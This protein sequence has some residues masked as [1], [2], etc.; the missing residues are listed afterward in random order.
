MRGCAFGWERKNVYRTE[1][2]RW[3]NGRFGGTGSCKKGEFVRKKVC[4]EKAR[5][6]ERDLE[7]E[8]LWNFVSLGEKCVLLEDV[9]CKKSYYEREW[10]R[11]LQQRKGIL[12]AEQCYQICQI[13][14]TLLHFK[15]SGYY[16]GIL[17]G[18]KQNFEPTTLAKGRIQSL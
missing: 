13:F 17:C 4:Q 10:K 8:R 11:D 6:K 18:V 7:R 9:Y 2:E 15:K 16:K 14:Y 12:W 3:W 1:R 5:Q